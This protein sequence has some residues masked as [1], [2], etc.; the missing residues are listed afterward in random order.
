MADCDD[1]L[2]KQKIYSLSDHRKKLLD[3]TL[4]LSPNKM[5]S[6]GIKKK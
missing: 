3:V 4:S 5:K 6:L 1:F 2:C